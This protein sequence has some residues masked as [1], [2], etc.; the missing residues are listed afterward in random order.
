MKR[1]DEDLIQKATDQKSVVPNITKCYPN[2][3]KYNPETFPGLAIDILS[4]RHLQ[5]L[6]HLA[7][8]LNCGRDTINIWR[9]Q[10]I[11]FAEAVEKG[12]ALGEEKFRDKLHDHIFQPQAQVNNGLIKLLSANVYGIKDES[13]TTIINNNN[14]SINPEDELI[15]RGIPLPKIE[16]EIETS[17][18]CTGNYDCACEDCKSIDIIED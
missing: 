11:E 8:A 9:K 1:T 13:P 14:T 5:S 4:S 6:T 18:E 15:R 10:Y 17:N 7:N 2:H 3:G 12:L 16:E